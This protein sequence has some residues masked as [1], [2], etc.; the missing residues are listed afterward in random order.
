MKQRIK[1]MLM[2]IVML[3]TSS[4]VCAHD[5]EVDG[6]YYKITSSSD[7]EVSVTFKGSSYSEY[8][9]YSGVVTIPEK[10]TYNGTT[11]GVTSIDNSAFRELKSL[12]NVI[13]EDGTTPLLFQSFYSFYNTAFETL[14]IGRDISCSDSNYS[15]FKYSS[16]SSSNINVLSVE[17]GPKVT[18][19][20]KNILSPFSNLKSLTIGASIL[21]IED[22]NKVKP[23]KTI[24]LGNS[25][26]TGYDYVEGYIN[27]AAN[28]NYPVDQDNWRKIEQLSSMFEI[29]GVKY[30]RTSLSTC[31]AIDCV[32]DSSAKDVNIGETVK[33]GNVT[34]TVD[35]INPYTCYWNKY[36]ETCSITFGKNIGEEAF[37]SCENITNCNIVADVIEASA[38]SESMSGGP[39]TLSLKARN[40]N[41]YCFSSTGSIHNA[42]IVVTDSIPKGAFQYSMSGVSATMTVETPIISDFAFGSTDMLNVATIKASTLKRS[43]FDGSGIINL[44]ILDCVKTIGKSCFANNSSMQTVNIGAGIN[45]IPDSV[46]LNCENLK[47]I[48]IPSNIESIDNYV[49]Y[50]CTNL[51]KV[52]I[53]D[54]KNELI[55]GANNRKTNITSRAMFSSCKLD[56]VYIGRNITYNTTSDYG[57]SPFHGNKYLRKVVNT[58]REVDITDEEFSSCENLQEVQLDEGVL[59]LGERA[60]SY[61]SLLDKIVLPNSIKTSIA[62]A[63]FSGCSALK[64]I[65]IGAGIP[66]IDNNAFLGCS[67][68]SNIEIP[69]N[70]DSIASGVFIGCTSLKMVAF[71]EENSQLFLNSNGEIKS[72]PITYEAGVKDLPMFKDCPLD[73]IYI[74][75]RL[76]YNA[77]GKYGF[78]PFCHNTTLRSVLIT[79]AETAISDY[80]FYACTNLKTIKMGDGVENIGYWSFSGCNDLDYVLFGTG[81]KTIG[82]EAFSDCT[83]VTKIYSYTQ[84]PPQ[85]DTQALDDIN[86][87][88]CV[89]Y[90]PK[91]TSSLYNAAPQWEWFYTE[92]IDNP[93]ANPITSISIEGAMTNVY[94]G[95][96]GEIPVVY[97]PADVTNRKFK[98]V[99]SDEN[100]LTVDENGVFTAKYEGTSTVTVSTTDGSNLSASVEINVSVLYGAVCFNVLSSE[101]KTLEVTRRPNIERYKGVIDIP[102]S[103]S[104]RGVDYS[105]VAIGDSA[106]YNCPEV[107]AV[108]MPN[109]I[110][111]IG[112]NSFS[113]CTGIKEI[114][115]PS[116]VSIINVGAFT[117]MNLSKITSLSSVPPAAE[118]AFDE[119]V[120]STTL[121]V[122]QYSDIEAYSKAKGWSVFTKI[123]VIGADPLNYKKISDTE[124]EVTNIG[125]K[126]MGDI[127]I[128]CETTID[129]KTYIV[130]SIGDYA[131]DSCSDLIS[132]TIPNSI[133]SIGNYA[134]S[135]CSSLASVI[136]GESVT[137]IGECAFFGCSGLTNITIPNS[138]VTIGNYAF[139]GCI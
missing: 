128:P 91:G 61:C 70:I 48:E 132:I 17:F 126:Y 62:E 54:S 93:V 27:Y 52:N 121:F 28:E 95:E 56:E 39:A 76:K 120:A 100:I 124:V 71:K 45:T 22:G 125:D 79:D 7:K 43:A 3:L 111:S 46:F 131:F 77:Q 74:G 47:G 107:S 2:L 106:F 64:D 29:G 105:V 103:M 82:E 117:S 90:V 73:S 115:I 75:R 86:E 41:E 20:K 66:S 49:F 8:D 94:V 104:V 31:E 63:C 137:S 84:T 23:K 129:G 65:T 97:T 33:K 30:V 113:S 81:M 37:Y 78:S 89:L 38:F 69:C 15:P 116:S 11:Y 34:M 4:A 36:I 18:S 138:V 114:T 42:N 72:N 109:T 80:E 136:I 12:K 67:S 59:T 21:S 134:F 55:L 135:G 68:L 32:Y 9:E 10:V 1:K 60:F 108:N 25:R 92:E 57:Y 88:D 101:N 139:Y 13:I 99:S 24:Y 51:A 35:Y 110:N 127:I 85:C 40:I 83:K 118:Y 6:I 112:Y 5:F 119:S 123:K 87:F 102:S 53:L 19:I 50:G 14:Y 58:A 122:P 44:E 26:P 130:T 133:T 16:S 98:W 96:T